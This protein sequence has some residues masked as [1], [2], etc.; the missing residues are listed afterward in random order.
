MH[1]CCS[2]SG[3]QMTWLKDI[4]IV[5]FQN[6][7]GLLVCVITLLISINSPLCDVLC[8]NCLI[9]NRTI[10]AYFQSSDAN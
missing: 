10:I 2:S 4:H 9:D 1:G 6:F 3:I 7:P 5:Q 8:F